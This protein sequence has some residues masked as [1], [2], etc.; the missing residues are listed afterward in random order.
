M[1]KNGFAGILIIL[2][3]AIL[4]IGGYFLYK[5][6]SNGNS[7]KLTQTSSPSQVSK[8]IVNT[9]NW[10]TFE[11]N[12]KYSI[13]YPSDWK[14]SGP[15]GVD[16]K[17]FYNPVF[18]SVCNY[19]NGDLCMQVFISSVPYGPLADL[20]AGYP[21]VNPTNKFAPD[22]IINSK[23]KTL[24]QENLIVDGEKAIGFEYFQSQYA[25]TKWQYVVV[26]DHN[27]TRYTITYEETQKGK[28]VI[29]PSDWKNKQIF[30]VML[31]TFKFTK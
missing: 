19:D 24:N 3:I 14:A 13:K 8:P 4:G 18:D 6:I 7:V 12:Y 28:N 9:S 21:E 22:F 15:G 27:S 10:V 25:G 11:S 26:F 20:S 17:T 30:D 5:N 29:T 2:I 1:K 23:D 16:P 31:S